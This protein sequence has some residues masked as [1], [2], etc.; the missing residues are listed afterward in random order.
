MQNKITVTGLC[1]P[2]TKSVQRA[3]QGI[4]PGYLEKCP[5]PDDALHALN[6]F[7][8]RGRMLI[9]LDDIVR[10]IL[11]PAIVQPGP[12]SATSV[13]QRWP[14]TKAAL[15]RRPE[16]SIHSMWTVPAVAEGELVDLAHAGW[17]R[18]F[19]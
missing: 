15:G 19:P 6:I 18:G 8:R 1:F 17:G 9:L 2:G 11:T 3:L 5:V 16:S 14:G 7:Q 4:E 13:G 12:R 10:D